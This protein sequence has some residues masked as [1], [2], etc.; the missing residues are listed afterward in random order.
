[1][2]TFYAMLHTRN[3]LLELQHTHLLTY[4]SELSR[5]E[6]HVE[7]NHGNTDMIH[8]ACNISPVM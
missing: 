7:T 6:S 4:L 2:E 8:V 3:M 5:L 1:V